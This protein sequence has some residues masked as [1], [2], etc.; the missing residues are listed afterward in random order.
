M[1]LQYATLIVYH[2]LLFFY[3][4]H[5]NQAAFNSEWSLVVFYMLKCVYWWYSALQIRAGYPLF[6]QSRPL[7]SPPYGYVRYYI[8]MS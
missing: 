7:T 1:A 5:G 6:V 3:L 2:W 4:P 8:C